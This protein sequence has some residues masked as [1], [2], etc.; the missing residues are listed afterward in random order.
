V[1]FIA[2]IKTLPEV[3]V[4]GDAFDE[5]TD[6]NNLWY[7]S[8]QLAKAQSP[9]LHFL[10]MSRLECHIRDAVNSLSIL[11]VDLTCPEMN[12]D[13]HTFVVEQL[14]DLRF[15]RISG[16]GKELVKESLISRAG[17]MYVFLSVSVPESG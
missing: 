2:V 16:D 14:D 4:F 15:A 17:G 9:S 13:I 8:S 11:T 10:F 7:F 5:C 6:W 1:C 3:R 12:L